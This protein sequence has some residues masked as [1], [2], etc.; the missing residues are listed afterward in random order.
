MNSVLRLLVAPTLPSCGIQVVALAILLV[1]ASL[2]AQD[3]ATTAMANRLK[4]GNVIE[5]TD[6]DGNRQTGR[7]RGIDATSIKVFRDGR[8]ETIPEARIRKVV[9]RDAIWNGVV[10][11]SA[12][13]T[14][15]GMIASVQQ[16][17]GQCSLLG[18]YG[19]ATGDNG[20]ETSLG[21]IVG[22][23]ALGFAVGW[24]VDALVKDTIFEKTVSGGNVRVDLEPNKPALTLK[25]AVRF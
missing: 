6:S 20:C 19:T 2:S 25:V 4:P 16:M 12:A 23:L 24:A 3:P 18:G 7:F 1:P 17:S 15:S 5:V 10:I 11:G 8:E 13:G 21:P 9:R 22:G 14:V